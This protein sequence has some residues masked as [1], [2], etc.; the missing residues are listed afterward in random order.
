[1]TA[2]SEIVKTTGQAVVER[3][4]QVGWLALAGIVG[5]ALFVATGVW[6]MIA[7]AS[8]A[9]GSQILDPT[10]FQISGIL[11]IGAVFVAPILLGVAALRAKVIPLWMAIYPIVAVAVVPVVLWTLLANV[12]DATV[13]VIPQG[14]AWLGF[15][16]IAYGNRAKG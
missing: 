16:A 13:V 12:I 11:F 3:R 1:M 9:D 8:N 14:L 2:Q 7:P 5:S 4:A 6:E 15:G 10:H